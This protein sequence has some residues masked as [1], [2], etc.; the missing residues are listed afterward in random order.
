MVIINLVGRLLTAIYS[1][2]NFCCAI[3]CSL[4]K[5]SS[6]KILVSLTQYRG[7]VGIFNNRLFFCA[8][9]YKNFSLII[10]SQDHCFLD[11]DFHHN[12]IRFTFFLIFLMLLTLN[13]KTYKSSIYF[14]VLSFL[15]IAVNVSIATWV[16][17]ILISLSGDVQ[18]NL[19]PKYKFDVNFSKCHRYLNSIAAHNYANVFL[20]KAYNAVYKFEIIRI[21]KTYLETTI[22]SDDGNLEILGYKLIRSD[23]PSNS[24]RGGVCIYYKSVLPLRILDIYYLQESIYF[25]LKIGDKLLQFYFFV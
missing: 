17:S 16:Y 4:G 25:E 22:T 1:F 19:G 21:S 12:D 18:L 20:L 14:S 7:T 24:K 23:H 10:H 6:L 2:C 5:F 15:I 13:C 3:I 8:L 9:K 11:F